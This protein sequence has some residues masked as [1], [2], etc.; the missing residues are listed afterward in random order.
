MLLRQFQRYRETHTVDDVSYNNDMDHWEMTIATKKKFIADLQAQ[1]DAL[2]KARHK[3]NGLPVD[4]T[5]GKNA[6]TR[7]V[8][9]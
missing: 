7:Y 3:G 5:I 9:P 6:P 4:L 8:W 1:V 2:E